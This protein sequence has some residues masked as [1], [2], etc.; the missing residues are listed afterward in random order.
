MNNEHEPEKK[1]SPKEKLSQLKTETRIILEHLRGLRN[2][3]E[4][5][6]RSAQIVQEKM[7]KYLRLL[8]LRL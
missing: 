4:S 3:S 5:N 8:N 2:Q 1:F 7:E 6:E